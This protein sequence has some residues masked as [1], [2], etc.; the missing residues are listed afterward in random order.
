MGVE[1]RDDEKMM[2]KSKG[3]DMRYTYSLLFSI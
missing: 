2:N 3:D 1:K